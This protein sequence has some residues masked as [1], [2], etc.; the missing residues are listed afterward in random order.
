MIEPFRASMKP[1]LTVADAAEKLCV[2]AVLFESGIADQPAHSHGRPEQGGLSPR[3]V[4]LATEALEYHST[5]PLV[6][7]CRQK[8]AP[9]ASIKEAGIEPG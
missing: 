2:V 8:A 4:E 6:M 9:P 1:R 5:L 7:Y 3:R